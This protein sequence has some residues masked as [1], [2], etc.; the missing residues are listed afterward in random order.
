MDSSFLTLPPAYEDLKPLDPPSLIE[1]PVRRGRSPSFLSSM[2]DIVQH[3]LKRMRSPA[4]TQSSQE[5]NLTVDW[6]P[7]NTTRRPTSRHS[8][9]GS[10]TGPCQSSC[11]N[12]HKSVR[13]RKARKREPVPSMA[14]YLTL[15]QLEVVWRSQDT[16]KGMVE[17][18]RTASPRLEELRPRSASESTAYQTNGRLNAW[19]LPRHHRSN[20]EID[21]VRDHSRTPDAL[22]NDIVEYFAK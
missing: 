9:C 14:D 4:R 12:P 19:S 10:H 2:K 15:E 11:R 7:R 1:P 20:D 5:D 21:Y 8:D 13:R 17:A 18:P 3:P 16:Y 22:Y 6:V